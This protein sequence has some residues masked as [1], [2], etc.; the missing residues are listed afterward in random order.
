MKKPETI[1]KAIIRLEIIQTLLSNLE[2]MKNGYKNDMQY[3]SERLEDELNKS[4]EEKSDWSIRDLK[5]SLEKYQ[6][7]YAEA[8][9]LIEMLTDLAL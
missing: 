4:E 5:E 1:S 7:R 6:D 9:T 8:N 3:Y 2:N